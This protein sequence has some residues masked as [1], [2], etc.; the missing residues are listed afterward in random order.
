MLRDAALVAWALGP[1]VEPGPAPCTPNHSKKHITRPVARCAAS[2]APALHRL[3]ETC[4]AAEELVSK[5]AQIAGGAGAASAAAEAQ[6]AWSWAG[7]VA[8]AGVGA[9]GAVGGRHAGRLQGI[10]LLV[11]TLKSYCASL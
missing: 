4:L 2:L 10:D 5:G 9:A 11:R 8:G 1:G 6:A 3:Q 7:D